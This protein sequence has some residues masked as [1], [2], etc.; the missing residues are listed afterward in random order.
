M[1]RITRLISIA[2]IAFALALATSPA[3]SAET[4]SSA[5]SGAPLAGAGGG[6]VIGT[7][8]GGPVGLVVGSAIGAL[9]GG[10]MQQQ[11][12]VTDSRR[13][14]VHARQR[15]ALLNTQLAEARKQYADLS[16]EPRTAGTRGTA[17]ESTQIPGGHREV[18]SED[19]LFRSASGKLEPLAAQRI[20]HLAAM[21]KAQPQLRIRLSGYADRRGNASENMTLSHQRAESVKQELVDAGIPADHITADWYGDK[22]AKAKIGD[23]EGLAMDRRVTV[24]LITTTPQNMQAATDTPAP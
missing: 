19:V 20:T 10:S 11:Q 1:Q 12:Q 8:V 21:I 18:C 6:A 7:L 14:L 5:V 16:R 9:I 15:V 24:E 3:R 4:T 13:Q 22:K 23:P 2:G 17:F